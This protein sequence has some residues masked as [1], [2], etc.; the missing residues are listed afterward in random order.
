MIFSTS[1]NT[2][3]AAIQARFITRT[4]NRT[5]HQEPAAAE[6]IGSVTQAHE[7]SPRSTVLPTSQHELQRRLA[8]PQTSL[9]ERCPLVDPGRNKQQTTEPWAGADHHGGNQRE[10]VQSPLRQRCGEA[11]CRPQ[12]QIARTHRGTN[13]L[14]CALR[15]RVIV[16]KAS[17]MGVAD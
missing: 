14:P 5:S 15:L 12:Y 2:L 6:A 13:A 17:S 7:K 10:A 11:E 16:A 4:A 9:F 3:S 1:T 8:V